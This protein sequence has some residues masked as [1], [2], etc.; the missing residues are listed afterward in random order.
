MMQSGG[1]FSK[2]SSKVIS[3]FEKGMLIFSPSVVQGR[4]SK[5]TGRFPGR[6]GKSSRKFFFLIPLK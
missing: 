3:I 2:S 1:I 4:G 6:K 5:K